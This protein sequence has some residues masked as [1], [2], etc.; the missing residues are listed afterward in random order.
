MKLA[1]KAYDSLGKAVT[2]TVECPDAATATEEL[3]HKGLFV[4]QVAEP[5]RPVEKRRSRLALRFG[6][7]QKTKNLAVFTRELYVLISSGTQ[8]VEALSA[9]E[10]QA[11]QGPWRD[12]IC[13]LRSK[14]EEGASL[15]DAM[16]AYPEYFDSVF[17]S[18]T[19]AG[20][21]GGCLPEMLDRLAT[22][23]Q[24]QLRVRNSIAG[25]MIYPTLLVAFSLT[26]LSLMLAFVVPRFA[27]LFITLDVPLPPSTQ[28][29]VGVSSLF[30]R[31]WWL[32]GV[33]TAGAI[34]CVLTYLRTPD[35]RRLRD[36]VALKLPYI[37]RLTRSLA[38]A[39][40][41]RLLGV[42]MEGHV[43]VL[44]ALRLIRHAAGNVHYAELISKAEAHVT[45]GEPI[46]LAFSDARL[47]APS[48]HEAIRSGEQS[49]RL[50]SLLL[51]IAGFLDDDNE[52]VLRSLTSIIEPAILI[53]MGVLVGLV[54]V[55]MF[56]PLFDLTS[57]TQGG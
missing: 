57:M 13:G 54:A 42:L 15:S 26:I 43:P 46:N 49:G 18:L 22:L 2:G 14:V 12:A 6:G 21:S 53:A 1:Y 47:I 30:R 55:S 10:R 4:A 34:A 56:M 17:R 28:A 39:R 38:T 3:R 20:E 52:V 16:E 24:K 50:G 11:K 33:L 51:E 35:G 41:V 7:G 27:T 23:K 37:A 29:L 8:L 25:A 44:E 36:T 32:L 31:F 45:R 5:L 9:L 48:V 40:I 19:E